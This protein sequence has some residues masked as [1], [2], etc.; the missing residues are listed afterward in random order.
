MRTADGPVGDGAEAGAA[1]RASARYTLRLLGTPVVLGADGLP[2]HGLGPGK[3]LALLAYLAVYGS[4]RR[5][6]LIELL[7]GDVTEDRARNAFRQALHRLRTALGESTIPQDRDMVAIAESG[8]LWVD[9]DAFLARLDAG[10]PA[11]AIDLYR[12]DFLDGFDVGEASFALWA[13]GERAR[14]RARFQTAL[15]HAAAQAL[16]AG[17][18][19]QALVF[20]QRLTRVA[21]LDEA[22]AL[23]EANV[24]VTA[25][26]SREALDSLQ[27][28][29]ARL[30]DELDL[31]AGSTVRDT[32]VR[33]QRTTAKAAS[34]VS[35][36]R[37]RLAETRFISRTAELTKLLAL[38]AELAEERGATVLIEGD[39]G[40]GKTRLI[41]EALERAHA[42]GP[43]LV[44]R[45]RELLTGSAV[46]YAGL[47][48]A[49]R[50]AVGA[51]GIA[52]TSQHLLTE[53]A[54]ILPSLRDA[55]VLPDPTPVLDAAGRL[56]F[57]EGV[58]AFVESAAFEQP[59][60]VVIDDL[61]HAPPSSIELLAYLT[62]RLRTSPVLF[63]LAYR[64]GGSGNQLPSRFGIDI[65]EETRATASVG[66]RAFRLQVPPLSE[67]D[68][69]ALAREVMGQRHDDRSATRVAAP[70]I[71]V[72]SVVAVAG[73]NPLRVIDVTR[74]ALAGE[75]IAPL[76]APIRDILWARLQRCAPSQRRV[77]FAAA[78]LQRSSSIR[79]L[80]AAAHLPEAAALDAVTTLVRDG[81]L[82]EIGNGYAIAHDVSS[83][84]VTELSGIAGRA[85]LA[86]WAADALAYDG[87]ATDAELAHL[88]S[89]AGRAP[90]AF[91]HSRAAAYAAFA[92]GVEAEVH[93]L[94]GLALTF[95]PDEGSRA[96]IQRLLAVVN[97]GRPLLPPGEPSDSPDVEAR[98]DAAGST[99]SASAADQASKP[100]DGEI[101][102]PNLRVR[103]WLA[104]AAILT[105]A[106][107][108][109]YE[110]LRWQAN[111]RAASPT[112][113]LIVAEVGHEHD[114]LVPFVAGATNHHT[115]EPRGAIT[116]LTSPAWTESLR[117]PW[118]NP[119]PSPD[120]KRI[121]L[122]RVVATGTDLYVITADRHDTTLIA[123]HGGDNVPLGWSPDGV[124]LLVS[125]PRTLAD[126]SFDSDLFVYEPGDSARRP[127]VPIDTSAVRSITE[128]Q[129]SPVG[130]DIAWVARSGTDRQQDVFVSHADGSGLR[131]ITANPAED[132]HIAWSP[133]GT[134][135][136]FTSD[137]GGAAN[138]Y[139]YDLSASKLWRLTTE[140]AHDDH[141]TFS[142]DGR[143]VAFEST[144]DGAPGV[145][146]MPALGGTAIRVTPRDRRFSLE[147]WR[148]GLPTYIR[149]IRILGPSSVAV[150]DTAAWRL[151]AIDDHG[152]WVPSTAAHWSVDAAS[153]LRL[154]VKPESA[155]ISVRGFAVGPGVARLVASLQGWRADTLVVREGTAAYELIAD[156]FSTTLDTSRWMPLGAPSPAT[157]RSGDGRPVLL[158]RGGLEW[159]SGVLSRTSI[160]VQE[161][162]SAQAEMYAPFSGRALAASR[163]RLAFVAPVDPAS[164]DR[165]A[166]QLTE[167]ASVAWVSE[168]RRVEYTV[169][170]ESWSE[171][172]SALGA[173][174][175]HLFRIVVER[176]NRVAFYV[177]GALRW[178][179][180]VALPSG[181]DAAKAQLWLGGRATSA[182]GAFA[183]VRVRLESGAPN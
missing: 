167:L 108:G 155:S 63:V 47:V 169:A 77:F 81:L 41:D 102:H 18:A 46:P 52:G 26:R 92:S 137:R 149:R 75:S 121:A 117:P 6:A 100:V 182:W 89:L 135:I 111:R 37:Q 74:R 34:P 73:G 116:R 166:P 140:S 123:A 35:S 65:G 30:R 107:A 84:F 99:Q 138:L 142:P 118:L 4:V 128:A 98:P 146:V 69:E 64:A 8:Q 150:H 95:A 105:A 164:L 39:A 176:G 127:P 31:A 104:A 62:G 120:G 68:A 82:T 131:N 59:V 42:L 87:S 162:L 54:R 151:F 58:A 78:L 170:P 71:D 183:N 28:F 110:S 22:G 45:G 14:L 181:T 83:S 12:G 61:H 44:L 20:A 156:S 125:R 154:S 143:F 132:Y 180:T 85:L 114:A 157:G 29:S 109:G 72:R 172:V 134:L 40:V 15:Q 141:A 106:F 101:R 51:P 70:A 122:Q 126:G 147:A 177:D 119:I 17:D 161:N 60:C 16:E 152:Q 3:P 174:D 175:R 158:P 178:R 179:S 5:D 112:D 90:E 148:G 24:L 56:R 79:L 13:D 129:W 66:A 145:Y 9:R 38:V 43:L 115:V 55:F 165:A 171:P 93:R 25:G 36:P 173:G 163:L 1:E 57:Y 103:G 19:H 159:E 124:R 168:S 48:E 86:G 144:R 53:A 88:Y 91:Q 160:D 10:L 133:D 11:S 130:I 21:P 80:A 27:R 49:L 67:A 94:L 96:E 97:A 33:L 23:L 153:A 136:A 2:A 139:A 50:G 113:S 76:P 7:W 32:I